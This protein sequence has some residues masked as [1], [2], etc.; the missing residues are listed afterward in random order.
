MYIVESTIKAPL[1]TRLPHILVPILITVVFLITSE[2]S[3]S[4]VTYIVSK[5]LA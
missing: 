2:L 4:V 5:G 1:I 3:L